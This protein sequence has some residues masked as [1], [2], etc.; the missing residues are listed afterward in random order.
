MP[1]RG[2][3]AQQLMIQNLVCTNCGVALSEDDLSEELQIC[4]TCVDEATTDCAFCGDRVMRMQSMVAQART[5]GAMPFNHIRTGLDEEI[6]TN[7]V[8]SCGNCGTEYT[9]EDDAAQCCPSEDSEHGDS[10]RMHYYS[11]RPSMKFW[12]MDTGSLTYGWRAKTSE[13]Y[14]G[15]EIEIEKCANYIRDMVE[16][17]PREDWHVPNFYYWKHDG[18]LGYDGSELVTMPATLDAHKN[19]FPF[20][21]L[22]ELHEMGARAWA[23]STC[24]M[25]IHVSRSAF[26]GPHMWKFIKFQLHNSSKIASISGRESA[27]WAS[28]HNDTMEDARFTAAKYTKT[29]VVGR[30]PM[31]YSALNFSNEQTVELRYFRSNIAEKGIIRNLELVHGIWAYTKKL[32]I[33][34]L[35]VHGWSFDKFVEYLQD[36]PEHSTITEYIKRERV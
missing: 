23:H 19:R 14:M 36:S 27:Q 13:L 33:A 10:D 11:F 8:S 24:G 26:T 21:M 16:Q 3:G 20:R 4:I 15:V 35:M 34:D 7:C 12:R 31:R 5:Y 25:H 6:C 2:T 22:D 28:W 32:T 17:D 30:Y 29:P 1:L 18:S 9:Y